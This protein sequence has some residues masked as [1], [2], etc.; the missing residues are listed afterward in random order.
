[1]Q[2]Q[3]FRGI[4]SKERVAKGKYTIERDEIDFFYINSTSTIFISWRKQ[5]AS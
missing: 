2:Q 1:M 5:W 4:N 3:R